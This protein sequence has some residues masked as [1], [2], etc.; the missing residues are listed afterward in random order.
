MVVTG[1]PV[2]FS[3]V[4]MD[5]QGILKVLGHCL[6]LPDE[7]EQLAELFSQ[8][9]ASFFVDLGWDGV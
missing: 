6:L 3:F 7:L 1:L 4:Q 8:G 9:S 2:S 5:Y